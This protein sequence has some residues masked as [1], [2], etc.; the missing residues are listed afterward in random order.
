MDMSEAQWE[1]NKSVYIRG[2]FS[3]RP[4]HDEKVARVLRRRNMYTEFGL[5]DWKEHNLDLYVVYRDMEPRFP[6]VLDSII[7]EYLDPKTLALL[8][9][10]NK[11]RSLTQVYFWMPDHGSIPQSIS[12]S[13][14]IDDMWMFTTWRVFVSG[15]TELYPI[16]YVNHDTVSNAFHPK[17]IENYVCALEDFHEWDMITR[18]TKR[19]VI[20]IYTHGNTKESCRAIK[21]FAE[22]FNFFN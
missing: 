12:L 2:D 6:K 11:V 20:S 1:L 13:P 21:F 7:I 4:S 9:Y 22:S 17:D 18:R 5:F 15:D 3:V 10:I 8:Y 19:C 14:M 16:C